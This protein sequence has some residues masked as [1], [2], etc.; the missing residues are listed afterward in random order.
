MKLI[1]IIYFVSIS[2]VLSFHCTINIKMVEIFYF[3]VVT[4]SLKF[5]VYFYIYITSQFRQAA[6]HMLDSHTSLVTLVLDRA[7]FKLWRV[8]LV[9]I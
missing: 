5:N 9:G 2:I 1:L 3:V 4:K 6:S 7:A 8:P